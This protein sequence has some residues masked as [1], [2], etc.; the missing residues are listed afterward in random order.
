M[1]RLCDRCVLGR[2][3]VRCLRNRLWRFDGLRRPRPHA[4]CHK[5]ADPRQSARSTAR[6]AS[7]R[8]TVASH[9]SR[10]IDNDIGRWRWQ[11]M[12]DFFGADGS[13]SQSHLVK[14]NGASS[15]LQSGLI[16][17][18]SLTRSGPT[19]ASRRRTSCNSSSSSSALTTALVRFASRPR[20][21]VSSCRATTA[22]GDCKCQALRASVGSDTT[23]RPRR[24]TPSE[25]GAE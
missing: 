25:V 16:V 20:W 21:C 2:T 24:S 15:A 18:P 1:P 8:H 17:Q 22:P 7:V 6:T 10:A 13:T 12:L 23:R 11:R 4:P 9:S 14:T 3:A 19:R 5:C